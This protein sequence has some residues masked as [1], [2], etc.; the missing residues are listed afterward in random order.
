MR[1]RLILPASKLVHDFPKKII[2]LRKDAVM[3]GAHAF[4]GCIEAL[5][6]ML[7]IKDDGADECSVDFDGLG[8]I[9]DQPAF[10][11]CLR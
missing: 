2:S 8:I 9:H 11:R 10:L 5:G 3:E 6:P 1:G 4:M 7:C